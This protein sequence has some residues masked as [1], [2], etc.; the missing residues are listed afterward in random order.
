MVKIALQFFV[1]ALDNLGLWPQVLLRIQAII[2]NTLSSS[3]GKTPNEVAYGFFLHY[4]LGLLAVLPTPDVL[5]A[6]MDAA[7][8]I[9]FALL[10]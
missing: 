9:F 5:A 6:C 1:Y 10:N 2:N 3:T 8:A 4:S 7:E